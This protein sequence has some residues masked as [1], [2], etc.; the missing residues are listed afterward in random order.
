MI[1][2]E[3]NLL[4]ILL[5]T[6]VKMTGDFTLDNYIY[7]KN[8]IN[9]FYGIIAYIGVIYL[10]IKSLQV[11][12]LLYVNIIWSGMAVLLET[13]SSV[14]IFGKRFKNIYHVLGFFLIFIGIIILHYY[15]Y[16]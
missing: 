16:D 1:I 8:Y 10:L 6:I 13:S 3:Y 9:L 2:I 5:L 15:R 14:I 4:L 12:P 7:T 11:Y